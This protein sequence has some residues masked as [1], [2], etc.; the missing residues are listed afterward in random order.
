LP[1]RALRSRTG[2]PRLPPCEM[3]A[4]HVA[5]PA[6][7]R[8][9]RVATVAVPLN[10]HGAPALMINLESNV[11]C[12]GGAALFDSCLSSRKPEIRADSRL[13]TRARPCSMRADTGD[14]MRAPQEQPLQASTLIDLGWTSRLSAIA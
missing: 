2:C 11:A 13:S 5:P 4:C 9:A 1:Q 10:P 8:L 12:A 7:R 6:D 3:G 14:C